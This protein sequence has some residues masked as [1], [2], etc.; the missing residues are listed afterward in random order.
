[1]S[2]SA[3]AKPETTEEER[4]S[5]EDIQLAT[6][7]I[8]FLVSWRSLI[9]IDEGSAAALRSV[10][11]C[12]CRYQ[13]R[14][15]KPIALPFGLG[16]SFGNRLPTPRNVEGLVGIHSVYEL[17]G[18]SPLAPAAAAATPG[19]DD[20]SFV[21][22]SK[23]FCVA[24]SRSW[25]AAVR[26]GKI[27]GADATPV[28]SSEFRWIGDL[29]NLFRTVSSSGNAAAI[30]ECRRL[31]A[32][33]YYVSTEADLSSG[34]ESHAG[35]MDEDLSST[36]K[37][38]AGLVS[39]VAAKAK[40]AALEGLR[41]KLQVMAGGDGELPEDDDDDEDFEPEEDDDEEEDDGEMVDVAAA[42]AAAQQE[43]PAMEP[44]PEEEDA[45]VNEIRDRILSVVSILHAYMPS[46]A[47]DMA[48]FKRFLN[49]RGSNLWF[50]HGRPPVAKIV[51][52]AEAL[53]ASGQGESELAQFL[54]E[55]L[56][57]FYDLQQ[58]QQ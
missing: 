19:D 54:G 6:K 3:P 13:D 27:T 30:A 32:P 43:L 21:H 12:L 7:T 48:F 53:H 8:D 14:F 45:S 41:Q 47:T 50:P 9:S 39:L 4:E 42:A 29:F 51:E 33:W 36:E 16:E 57:P 37:Q 18:A 22:G 55:I 28:D 44:A 56:V 24:G 25:E 11:A 20:G 38:I 58:K 46:P 2:S 26:S 52:V 5:M 23:L 1:M 17:V 34:S 10:G 40:S 31:A 49:S 15:S 35:A